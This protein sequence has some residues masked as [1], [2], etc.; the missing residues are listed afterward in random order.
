MTGKNNHKKSKILFII[1]TRPEILKLAI[2]IKL[3]KKTSWAE[4]VVLVTAQ[5]REL[6]DQML[7]LHNITPDLDLNIMQDNQDLSTLTGKLFIAL[8]DKINQIKPEIIIAQGDTTTVMVASM[9]AFYK[10]ITFAHVEAGLRSHDLRYPFPEEVNRTIT[11]IVA[12]LHFAPTESDKTN[13]MRSGVPENKIFVVGNTIIDNLLEISRNNIK[14]S[15]D[16]P[17]SKKIIL[18]T[19]H[20]RENF[21]VP[22]ENICKAIS[23]IAT[24]HKD[25]CFVYP[26]H[27]NPNVRSVVQEH[28]GNNKR[29]MLCNPLDYQEFVSLMTRCHF[30]LSDSGGIQ[31]EAP[32]LGK[33]VLVTRTTTERMETVDLGTSRLIGTEYASVKQELQN[34]LLDEDLYASMSRVISPYGDGTA[35]TQIIR[36][37][38]FFLKK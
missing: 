12:D 18:V 6:L 22:L 27:P 2:L 31:E 37:L 5:H 20:R 19:L 36:V 3:L 33:P 4:V 7:S 29:I 1:G 34:L 32:A 16:M 8:S 14:C 24:E 17:D 10:H 21:G 38:K 15:L 25:V 28:L 30:I 9:V 26:V 11:G 13:L 35:S 23:E